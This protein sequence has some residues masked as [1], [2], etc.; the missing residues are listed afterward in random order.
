MVAAVFMSAVWFCREKSM[1][2]LLWMVVMTSFASQFRPESILCIGLVLATIGLLNPREFLGSRLW[3]AGLIG[4]VLSAGLIGHIAAVRNEGWGSTGARFSFDY[5]ANN[6]HTNG[7]FYINNKWFPAIYTVLAVCGIYLHRQ[8]EVLLLVLYFA[9]FWGVF[10]FFYAGSY[11]YGADVR[12]SLM[13]YPAIAILAGRGLSSL[14]ERVPKT[15]NQPGLVYAACGF[16]L[17]QFLMFIPLVRATGE[18]AWSARSDV[19]FAKSFISVLPGNS[20]VLTHN[21]GMFHVWGVN[22]AQMSIAANEPRYV[23]DHLA[24]RYSGG[25]YL[26]WNFWCNVDDPVQKEFCNSTLKKFSSDLVQEYKIRHYRFA[27]YKIQTEVGRKQE[28]RKQNRRAP[29]ID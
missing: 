24:Q 9:L 17:F 5:L 22:A 21:P 8:K 26:H 1:F 28:Q 14:V 27:F 7:L 20:I 6:L 29:P 4:L 15:L 13:S 16:I 11:N 10:I 23:V 12:Y 19:E 25:V 2:A 3:W 18:E